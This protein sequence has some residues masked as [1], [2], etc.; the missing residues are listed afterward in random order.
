MGIGGALGW[1]KFP[2]SCERVTFSRIGDSGK[3]AQILERK[4][5]L[6]ERER[7]EWSGGDKESKVS[8]RSTPNP[9]HKHN[10]RKTTLKD[11]S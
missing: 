11:S 1:R 5:E 9:S 8:A 6:R 2:V 10:V 7:E 3:A 4:W